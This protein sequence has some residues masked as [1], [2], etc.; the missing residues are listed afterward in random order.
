MTNLTEKARGLFVPAT[1]AVIRPR[2]YRFVGRRKTGD[3]AF[4]LRMGAGSPGDITRH[5]PPGTLEQCLVAAIT[6]PTGYGQAVVADGLTDN[7][8]RLIQ[9]G[10]TALTAIY[11]I[12]ARPYPFQQATTANSYG[13]VPF[14][15]G[16][17]AINQPV[18]VLRSGYILA[19][20]NATG[21]V[22]PLK[23]G[24]VYVWIAASSGAHVQGSFESAAT[25]GSTI[26]LDSKSTFQGGVDASGYGEIALNI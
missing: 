26:A 6:P 4:N 2:E 18:D 9:A 19:F 22:A 8:V 11:G 10:D 12:T 15:G 3:V 24:I 25:G 17:L 5:T 13:S 23:G 1:P 21:G 7:A 16:V 14:G 20:I